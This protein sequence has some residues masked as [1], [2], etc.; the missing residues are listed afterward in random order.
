MRGVP[1]DPVY[2]SIINTV[3]QIGGFMGIATI[4]EEVESEPTPQKLRAL[5]VGDAQGYAVAAPQ[6]LLNAAGRVELP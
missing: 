5:G 4:A 1:Q 6:P 3:N 2:G